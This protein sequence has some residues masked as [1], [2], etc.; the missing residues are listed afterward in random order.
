MVEDGLAA[1]VVLEVIEHQHKLFLVV[2]FIQLQLE[3]EVRQKL[4]Q[5]HQVQVILVQILQYPEV[6]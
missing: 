4:V 5:L 3:M 2:Q 6:I 1:V